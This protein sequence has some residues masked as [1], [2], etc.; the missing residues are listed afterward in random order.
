MSS[1]LNL[2]SGSSRSQ[3]HSYRARLLLEQTPV[4]YKCSSGSSSTHTIEQLSLVI[5][6]HHPEYSPAFM[7]ESFSLSLPLLWS[8]TLPCQNKC[9]ETWGWPSWRCHIV[10]FI[11]KTFVLYLTFTVQ[12]VRWL[13]D[14]YDNRCVC[15]HRCVV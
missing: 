13:I 2:F 8:T 15:E 11:P 14:I 12:F 10:C 7:G 9:W 4:W 6:F 3:P 5:V 1:K